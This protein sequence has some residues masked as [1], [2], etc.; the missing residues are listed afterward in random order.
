MYSAKVT[1]EEDNKQGCVLVGIVHVEVG[2]IV[3][4]YL[5]RAMTEISALD[6]K[7]VYESPQNLAFALSTEHPVILILDS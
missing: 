2:H 5:S 6:V 7:C 1:K 4:H 3:L